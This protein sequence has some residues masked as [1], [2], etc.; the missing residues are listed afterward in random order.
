MDTT[1]LKHAQSKKKRLRIKNCVSLTLLYNLIETVFL[2]IIW[3]KQLLMWKWESFL[4]IY[5]MQKRFT[6]EKPLLMWNWESFLH[7][8]SMQKGFTWEKPSLMW[9]LES[10]LHLYSMQKWLGSENWNIGVNRQFNIF[11]CKPLKVILRL[12]VTGWEF[13][14]LFTQILNI[15]CNIGPSNLEITMSLSSFWSR[16]H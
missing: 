2:S 16:Y 6:W 1:F 14:K 7:F 5:S 3:E 12:A 15:F 8:Y 11:Y 10:F 9:K 13:T 4:H